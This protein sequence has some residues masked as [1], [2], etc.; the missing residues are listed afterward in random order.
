MQND[1]DAALRYR[2]ES[3]LTMLDAVNEAMGQLFMASVAGETARD[4]LRRLIATEQAIALDPA[5]SAD[6]AALVERGRVAGM[7]QAAREADA[8]DGLVRPG[9]YETDQYVGQAE[10]GPRVAERIAKRVRALAAASAT[11]PENGCGNG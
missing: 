6:A 2:V 8:D 7:E 1:A 9:A 11:P 4:T 3:A 5:V 10:Y